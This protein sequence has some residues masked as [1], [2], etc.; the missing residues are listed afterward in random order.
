MLKLYI[1]HLTE[2]D[3]AALLPLLSKTRRAKAERLR[4]SSQKLACAYGELL[5]SH[6]FERETGRAMS[7]DS[8][9]FNPYGKPYSCEYPR[10]NFSIS[11]SGEYVMLGLA[12]APLGVDVQRRKSASVAAAKRFFTSEEYAFVVNGEEAGAG[13]RFADLWAVKESYIKALGTG[14]ATPLSS[15]NTANF[16]LKIG[17]YSLSLLNGLDE[18]YS[19]AVC[20]QG[21]LEKAEIIFV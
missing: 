16:P 9:S 3:P 8:L 11:H 21:S 20:V 12:S 19:W 10:L 4:S 17:E 2:E 14:L 6:A 15:F 1:K 5:L 18:A 7:F 13:A